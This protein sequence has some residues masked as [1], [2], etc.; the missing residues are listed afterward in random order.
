MRLHSELTSDRKVSALLGAVLLA[1]VSFSFDVRAHHSFPAHYRPDASIE[2]TGTVSEFLWRNPHTF[3]H[4]EV[5]DESG[6]TLIWAVE[7]N[8]TVTMTNAGLTAD[9][10]APGDEVVITGNPSRDG[11]RRMR[12]VTLKRPADG[13]DVTRE[14]GI[15]D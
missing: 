11:T 5:T 4:L 6:E 10:L 1:S 2:L 7:W 12:L 14:G 8:N 3:I 15:N 13:L 9:L